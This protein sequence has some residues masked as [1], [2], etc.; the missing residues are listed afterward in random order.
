MYVFFFLKGAAPALVACQLASDGSEVVHSEGGVFSVMAGLSRASCLWC[1]FAGQS[2]QW[3]R[4]AGCQGPFWLECQRSVSLL[5]ELGGKVKPPGCWP[6]TL[7]VGFRW[8]RKLLKLKPGLLGA[9]GHCLWC[10]WTCLATA[11]G[12]VIWTLW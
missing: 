10:L 3:I 4:L 1:V 6:I 12:G 7:G 2:A 9:D 11:A 8:L 5:I